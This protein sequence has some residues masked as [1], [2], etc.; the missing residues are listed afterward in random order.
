MIYYYN[1]YVK[2]LKVNLEAD[3]NISKRKLKSVILM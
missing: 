2:K 3:L 1:L